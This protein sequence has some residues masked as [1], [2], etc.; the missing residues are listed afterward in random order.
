MGVVGSL[1]SGRRL[2]P[3][4]HL[5]GVYVTLCTPHPREEADA[6]RAPARNAR[7]RDERAKARHEAEMR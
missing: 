7:A 1:M 5:G 6:V 2:M 4:V 3:C